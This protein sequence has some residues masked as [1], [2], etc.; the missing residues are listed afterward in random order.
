MR[1]E[2]DCLV[3]GDYVLTKDEQG[4]GAFVDDIAWQ[5]EFQLD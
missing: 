1:T 3:M 5:E 4:E 2:M